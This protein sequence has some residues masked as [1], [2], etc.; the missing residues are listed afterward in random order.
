[1]VNLKSILVNLFITLMFTVSFSTLFLAISLYFLPGDFQELRTGAES[2]LPGRIANSTAVEKLME[3]MPGLGSVREEEF[4]VLMQGLQLQCQMTGLDP[5]IALLCEEMET[6]RL[7]T[8][9]D[10]QRVVRE[11]I[12]V[13]PL[14]LEIRRLF[15][16]MQQGVDQARGSVWIAVLVSLATFVIGALLVA[17]DIAFIWK[18]WGVRNFIHQLAGY[19]WGFAFFTFLP[20]LL[21]WLIFPWASNWLL[22]QIERIVLQQFSGAGELAL[23][24]DM[25]KELV[26]IVGRFMLDALQKALVKPMAVWG[27]ISLAALVV[28]LLTGKKKEPEKEKQ[29][30]EYG[31]ADAKTPAP[32][33]KVPPNTPV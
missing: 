20:L 11:S 23:G 22:G 9:Q 29:W 7:Q 12:V 25:V 5:Q 10:Y 26:G 28:R 4:Q 31:A 1:M 24:G 2:E 15:V 16:E 18:E 17:V 30:K 13:G 27:V 19:T 14:R 33:S 21:L 3:Q 32:E 8:Q 6:G